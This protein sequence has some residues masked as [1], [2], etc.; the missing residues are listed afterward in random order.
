MEFT[1]I[2]N[3]E[4]FLNQV[5]LELKRAERYRIFLSMVVFDFSFLSE[6]PPQKSKEI[7]DKIRG[8]THKNVRS[9]DIISQFGKQYLALLFPE[10]SRQ[11]AELTSRRLADEIKRG[12]GELMPEKSEKA[13]NLEMSSF[14]D[15]GG[16]KTIED[17]LKDLIQKSRN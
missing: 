13:I 5:G 10:T 7:I 2:T 9:S 1:N 16:A 4:I 6:I 12:I 14:P 15:T 8:I 11:G 3:S 17:F